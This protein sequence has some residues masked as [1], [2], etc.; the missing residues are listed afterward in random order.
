MTNETKKTP[1]FLTDWGGTTLLFIGGVLF[2]SGICTIWTWF[3]YEEVAWKWLLSP[4]GAAILFRGYWVLVESPK[5]S[6]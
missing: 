5:K 2:F 1:F 3:V 4:S 6:E